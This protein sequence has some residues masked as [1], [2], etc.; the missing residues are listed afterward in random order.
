MLRVCVAWLFETRVSTAERTF[1]RIVTRTK[2]TSTSDKWM[3]DCVSV[4]LPQSGR[5]C[6][7]KQ[8]IKKSPHCTPNLS[9]S[10]QINLRRFLFG[11]KIHE[12]FLLENRIAAHVI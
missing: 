6:K 7:P 12:K 9:K 8:T 2:T 11:K 1:W 10:I 3:F 5:A 4:V